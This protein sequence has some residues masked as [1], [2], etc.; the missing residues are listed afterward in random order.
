MLVRDELER[1]WTH[2]ERD[3]AAEQV[4]DAD[5]ERRDEEA[6]VGRL[7]EALAE[8]EE[9]GRQTLV[10]LVLV[11]ALAAR[12][13]RRRQEASALRVARR[14]G[15]R[16]AR[17]A[18]DDVEALAKDRRRCGGRREGRLDREEGAGDTAREG[19]VDAE[20]RQDG[21]DLALHLARARTEDALLQRGRGDG[22]SSAPAV[23]DEVESGADAPACSSSG[24]GSG[25]ARPVLKGTRRRPC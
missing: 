15:A 6:R 1:R 2:E 25:R 12:R 14:I 22:V 7:L 17:A 18:G 13:G 3:E 21:V 20:R 8:L 4:R 16:E 23:W 9:E 24:S 10:V 19:G 5:R 11:V